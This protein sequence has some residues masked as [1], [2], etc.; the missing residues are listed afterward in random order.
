MNAAGDVVVDVLVGVNG[1]CLWSGRL[2]E[3]AVLGG[4][5]AGLLDVLGRLAAG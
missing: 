3:S 4:L 1:K 5:A 2:G